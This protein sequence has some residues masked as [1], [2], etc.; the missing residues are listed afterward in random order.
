MLTNSNC[1]STCLILSR[2]PEE[3]FS[4][5]KTFTDVHKMNCDVSH[6]D[7]TKLSFLFFERQLEQTGSW[8]T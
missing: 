4:K 7:E 6:T 5:I 2:N 8:R 1:I 3:T